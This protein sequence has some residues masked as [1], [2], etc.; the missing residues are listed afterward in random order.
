MRD[1][2]EVL[3]V[4][5]DATDEEIKTAYRKLAKKYHPDLNPGDAKAAEKMNEINAAY[6]R[7]RNGDTDPNS[8]AG[9]YGAAGQRYGYGYSGYQNYGG[10]QSYAGSQKY[11]TIIQFINKRQFDQ[12]VRLLNDVPAASRDAEWFFLSA[13]AHYGM[14]N[15][16]TALDHAQRAVTMDPNNMQYRLFLQQ[17]QQG[18]NRYQTNSTEFHTVNMNTSNLCTSLCMANLCMRFCCFGC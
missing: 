10:Y 4:S 3:G 18:S 11:A 13:N 8:G 5:R 2:Y 12:A 17:L 16:I 15:T 7:I 6:D 14:G 9:A 1:P